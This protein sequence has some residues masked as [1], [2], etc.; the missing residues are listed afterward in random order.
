MSFEERALKAVEFKESGRFNCT[1]A[2]LEAF[3]DRMEVDMDSALLL[4]TGFAAG[5][6]SMEATCGAL[7][8]A[9]MVAGA[10]T[11][12]IATPQASAQ[13][14]KAFD[15]RSGATICK[16]L[17]GKDTGVVL[18]SCSDCVKNAVLALG[19]VLD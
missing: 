12:G 9:V 8:G 1:Q 16:D 17:K 15:L 13:I 3:E 19:D 2:V 10:L 18:C 7:I 14:L 5:M 11:N 6:G 4:S